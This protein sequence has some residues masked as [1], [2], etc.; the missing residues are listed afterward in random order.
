MKVTYLEHSGFAA[1]YKEYVLI[2]DWYRGSLPEFDQQKKIYVFASHSHYDHFN[3]KIF[4]WSEQY[5]D[6]RYILSADIAGKEQSEEQSERTVYVTAN[7]K[8][9]FDGIKVQTLHSTD[10]GVA[11]IVYM[12]DKV[13]YHAGDLNWWHWEEETE[14]YN[15]Q[16][17]QDYQREIDKL[18]AGQKDNDAQIAIIY[19]MLRRN[20][21]KVGIYKYDAFNVENSLSGGSISFALTLLNS[22]DNGFILNVIHNRAGCHVYLKEIKEAAC[23]QVLAAEEKI[24]LDMALKYDEK[25]ETDK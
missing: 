3:K 5:P 14:S 16:M 17:R 19:D 12:E 1:E 18:K 23:E 7:T 2:F 8:Y 21:S 10:E 15:E 22:R 6:V 13:I 11:F 9:D 24:S 4:G 20:Y 25:K